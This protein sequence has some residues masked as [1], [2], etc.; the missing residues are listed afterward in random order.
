MKVDNV[1]VH[2]QSYLKVWAYVH[3]IVVPIVASDSN[4]TIGQYNDEPIPLVEHTVDEHVI[5]Q[6][7]NSEPQIPLRR[8]GRERKS[9]ISNDYVV[10]NIENECDLSMDDDPISFKMAMES[11]N[12]EEWFD[13]SKE[14]RKFMDDNHVWDLVELPDGFKTI[15]SKWVYK[16]KRDSKEFQCKDDREGLKNYGVVKNSS[17]VLLYGRDGTKNLEENCKIE[18]SIPVSESTLHTLRLDNPKKSLEQGF[19]LEIK[20]DCSVCLES[21]GACGYNHISSGFVCYCDDATH[22]QNCGS[23]RR[24]KGSLVNAIHK[25]SLIKPICKVLGSVAG[26]VLFV[27][28]LSFFLHFL[29]K[30]ELRLRQQNLMSL[31]PLK[32]YTYAQVKRIT[33]SFAEVVGRGGFGIVYRGTLSDGR[34]VAVRDVKRGSKRAII[35]EFLGNGSLDKFISR[36]SSVNL[37]WATLYQIALGVA[38]GLEYLHHGCKTRIVHFDIKPQN[39][40]LDEDFCPIVSD[41]GLAKLCEKKESVLSLLDT[42]GT[43]GYIAPEMISRVYGSVSHK[44]DVCSYGML[45]LEMIGARNKE[46]AHQD[47]ASNTSSIYFPEWVY[48][49]LELGKPRRLIENGINN[50]EEEVAKKMAL[51]GLWCIQPSPLDRPPMNRVVEMMEGS[52]EA[53]EVPPRPVLQ[54]IP[55]APLQESLTLSGSLV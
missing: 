25:G 14:E 3:N 53:L 22:G 51:V 39:V 28:L 7:E 17:S 24:S 20:Q 47:S 18:V 34:M 6:E 55:T 45:V 19:N 1:L 9:A 35:Y 50:E 33:K 27:I 54:Q 43:V 12:S 52:L 10:Y 11:D 41:F 5:I 31:I 21:K 2:L 8:S 44:S 13:A 15:G 48:R 42:R 32:H 36:K 30:R 40:L 49:D 29:R 4:D 46:S 38:R 26:V 16:T 37:D 23:G